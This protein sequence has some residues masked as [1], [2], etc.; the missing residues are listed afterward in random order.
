[1]N[2]GLQSP[3]MRMSKAL[4]EGR[5][6]LG[7][8]SPVSSAVRWGAGLWRAFK[9]GHWPKIPFSEE[10]V[11]TAPRRDVRGKGGGPWVC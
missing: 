1:M 10:E 11:G 2:W 7:L 5:C 3:Q 6:S 4:L 9:G 8:S